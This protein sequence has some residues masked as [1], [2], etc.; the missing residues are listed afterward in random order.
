MATIIFDFDDTLFDTA[1]LKKIIFGKLES[2]GIHKEIVESTYAES[3]KGNS[4][5]SLHSHIQLIK[6]KYNHFI[7]ENIYQWFSS[8]DFSLYLFPDSKTCLQEL[9]QKHYLVLLT[10]GDLDFQNMKIN[11]C[12]IRKYFKEI[13]IIENTKDVFLKEKVFESPI[14]FINDKDSENDL[15]RELF[16]NFTIIP[17]KKGEPLQ[18]SLQAIL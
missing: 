4:N 13:Y 10:K 3:Q 11:S 9:S 12:D 16:P 1:E 15:I 8:I 2:F 14:Y 18:F 17:K 7:P 5:Y 6:E